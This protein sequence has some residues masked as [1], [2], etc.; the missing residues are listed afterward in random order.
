MRWEKQGTS[1]Y[2]CIVMEISSHSRQL[3]STQILG[4]SS[5]SFFVKKHPRLVRYFVYQ[6]N[7]FLF[8]H[9]NCT[10]SH[11][12]ISF[13]FGFAFSQEYFPSNVSHFQIFTLF[14]YNFFWFLSVGSDI[15]LCSLQNFL[16]LCASNYYDGCLFH[17]FVTFIIYLYQHTGGTMGLLWG[18]I[19]HQRMLLPNK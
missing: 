12:A 7:F 5:L 10:A 11:F 1:V 17:R 6:I 8:I 9:I 15:N 16:A 2:C 18:F 3:Q 13:V 14:L 4:I 19:P